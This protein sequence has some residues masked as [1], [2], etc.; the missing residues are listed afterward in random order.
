VEV[1]SLDVPFD[2]EVLTPAAALKLVKQWPLAYAS[3]VAVPAMAIV[4]SHGY[5][6]LVFGALAMVGVLVGL[7][8]ALVA[9]HSNDRLGAFFQEQAWSPGP[10]GP[11]QI[12][13][14][15]L[16]FRSAG[17]WA[18]FNLRIRFREGGAEHQLELPAR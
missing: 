15:L 3:Y 7:P 11:G 17:P 4:L 2:V 12:R 10:L 9:S 6:G 1:V 18:P 8:N 13:R 16:F 14:G 5:E